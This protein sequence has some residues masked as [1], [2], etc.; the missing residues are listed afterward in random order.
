MQHYEGDVVDLGLFFSVENN[1]LGEMAET[2]LIPGGRDIPVTNENKI[3][4]IY[5]VAN[6]RLNLQVR[7]T[8]FRPVNV[9]GSFRQP[10]YFRVNNEGKRTR[11]MI[12]S[13]AR[14]ERSRSTGWIPSVAARS[15][16][17]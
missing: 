4:Y 1:E 7:L 5:L 17:S 13:A 6:H 16:K 10:A 8:G 12:Y 3:K 14:I 15:K 9:A 2:E 11:C